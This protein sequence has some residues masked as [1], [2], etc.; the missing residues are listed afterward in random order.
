MTARQQALLAAGL[1]LYWAE[2]GKTNKTGAAIGNLDGRLLQVFAAF[3]REV[4][5]VDERRLRVYVRVYRQFSLSAAQRYWSRLLYLPMQRVFVYSHTDQRSRFSRQW[6][7]YGLATLQFHST[8]F[9]RWLDQAIE[10][11][12]SFLLYNPRSSTVPQRL[13]KQMGGLVGD[14]RL[15]ASFGLLSDEL[16][17]IWSQSRWDTRVH[18][19]N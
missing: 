8:K 12:V 10:A 1:L 13:W 11:Y 14:G 5:R 2:G 9:K 18:P 19:T 7:R 15:D 17:P 16:L 6:S 4:C 3:L